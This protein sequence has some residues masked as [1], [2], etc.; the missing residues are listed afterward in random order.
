[1][2]GKTVGKQ[3]LELQ[4]WLNSKGANVTEDGKP[5]PATRTATIETFRNR[6]A[7]AITRPL[8]NLIAQRLGA[9]SRQLAAFT[10]TESGGSGWD[11]KGLLK[12]LYERHYLF[13]RV[14]FAVPFLSDPKPGGYTI[15]A[16][17]DGINDSWEKLA[18]ATM[19]FGAR[20]AFECASFGEFQVM[21]AHWKKLGYPSVL[22]MVWGL[23]RDQFAHYELFARYIEFNRLQR[24]LATVNGNPENARA[25][26]A[27]YNGPGYWKKGYH[28]TIARNW[29]QW[30]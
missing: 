16:D 10:R 3:T 25:I 11:D 30:A 6:Q 12:C 17:R 19:R 2:G 8:F 20:F 21:G 23:S 15:D 4:I 28:E 26:A 24:A 27:G 7:A 29:R 14:R 13:K 18:D 5:G 9:T 1:M 22:E